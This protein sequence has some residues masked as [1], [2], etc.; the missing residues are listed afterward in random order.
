MASLDWQ[1]QD[2]L[3][4]PKESQYLCL[5]GCKA[6]AD[7]VNIWRYCLNIFENWDLIDYLIDECD[8]AL[9]KIQMKT[10]VT[11]LLLC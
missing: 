2:T 8:A 7:F 9:C 3:L 5:A 4:V 11:Y 6:I 10:A 1:E